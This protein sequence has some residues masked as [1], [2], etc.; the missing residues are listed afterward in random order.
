MLKK[1]QSIF[2]NTTSEDCCNIEIK[3]VTSDTNDCC[4]VKIEEVKEEVKEE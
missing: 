1:L 2:G 3:E 4:G